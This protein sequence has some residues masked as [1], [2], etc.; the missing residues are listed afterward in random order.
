M[1]SSLNKKYEMKG[2]PG[3]VL[4]HERPGSENQGERAKE[5]Q[6]ETGCREGERQSV[7]EGVFDFKP[8]SG[9]QGVFSGNLRCI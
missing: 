6:E 2:L 4:G 9:N 8:L 1:T 7:I 3:D 5:R